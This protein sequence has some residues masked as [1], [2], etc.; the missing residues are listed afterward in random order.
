MMTASI[1]ARDR[2]ILAIGTIAIAAMFGTARG[3]PMLRQWQADRIADAR[4]LLDRRAAV[5]RAAR[6]TPALRDSLRAKAARLAALDSSLLHAPSSYAAAAQLASVL[7]DI[8]DESTVKV[9]AMQLRADSVRGN[10]VVHVFVRLSGVTDVIGLGDLMRAI[11]DG[12]TMLRLAELTITQ[13]EPGA[14]PSQPE[15]LRI[16]V[17]VEALA[18]IAIQGKA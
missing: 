4:E 7:D 1:S 9:S 17:V 12:Q 15:A 11:D 18:Q 6:T 14:A 8:A 3:L 5:A 16:D 13:A 2:R 10:G